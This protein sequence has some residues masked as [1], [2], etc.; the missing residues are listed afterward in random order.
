MT[1]RWVST[2]EACQALGISQS[3]LR[4]RID[5][6]EVESKVEDGRRLVQVTTD[7]QV[8]TTKEI[9]NFAKEKADLEH[10]VQ[11]LKDNLQKAEGAAT[12]SANRIDQLTA[13]KTGVEKE[14]RDAE[15]RAALVDGLMADKEQLQQQLTEKDRQIESLQTQLQDAGQRHDTVVMQMSKMLEYERQ[16][17]WRRWFTYKALPA[18]GDVMDMEPGTEEE[19]APEED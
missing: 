1:T 2:I 14:L 15:K 18:P 12:S 6:G 3:T 4:R 19:A 10:E 7:N 9:D 13:E 11:D 5:K 16:P 17:F 8:V